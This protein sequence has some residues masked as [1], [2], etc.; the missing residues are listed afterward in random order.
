VLDGHGGA[1]VSAVVARTFP[2]FLRASKEFQAGNYERAL[3]D[4]FKAMDKWLITPEGIKQ[5]V[6]ERYKS[7][8][9]ECTRFD[10]YASDKGDE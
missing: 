3:K 4:T 8:W 6:E 7:T 2:A 9:D 5:L 1:E 10:L